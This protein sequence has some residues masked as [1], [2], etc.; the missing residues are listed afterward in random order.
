MEEKDS[1]S[2]PSSLNICGRPIIPHH[3]KDMS[4][5]PASLSRN[6]YLVHWFVSK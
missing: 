5:S 1:R 4:E 6:S 3:L 2:A